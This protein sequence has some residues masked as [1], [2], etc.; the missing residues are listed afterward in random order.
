MRL[1]TVP[2]ELSMKKEGNLEHGDHRYCVCV[3]LWG[4]TVTVSGHHLILI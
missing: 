3:A 2:L 1:E 4:L